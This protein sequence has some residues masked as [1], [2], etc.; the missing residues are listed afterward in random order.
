MASLKRSTSVRSLPPA[1]IDSGDIELGAPAGHISDAKQHRPGKTPSTSGDRGYFDHHPGAP[2]D[3]AGDI[4][5]NDQLVQKSK[6][7]A[8]KVAMP[9]WLF[10]LLLA[11]MMLLLALLGACVGIFVA[12][13]WLIIRTQVFINGVQVEHTVLWKMATGSQIVPGTTTVVH[14][15]TEVDT[16]QPLET[17]TPLITVS[18]TVLRTLVSTAPGRTELVTATEV[19]TESSLATSTNKASKITLS[20]NGQPSSANDPGLTVVT[21]TPPRSIVTSVTLITTTMPHHSPPPPV[22]RTTFVDPNGNHQ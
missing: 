6:A 15:D 9:I 20:N 11:L 2:H 18:E 5:C 12:K 17:A 14:T 3:P 21:V 4:Q 22:N 7:P 13:Q 16:H 10:A 19:V 1:Y 8:R